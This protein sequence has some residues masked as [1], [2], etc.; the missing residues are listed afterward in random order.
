MT[1]KEILKTCI[2]VELARRNFFCFCNLMIPGMYDKK[3]HPYLKKLCDDL[4]DFWENDKRKYF[5]LS[6]PPRHGKTLTIGLF[7]DWV[8]GQDK[9]NKVMT[10]SYNEDYAG[11]LSKAIR[12]R[13]QEIKVDEDRVIYSDVF[14]SSIERGSAQAKKFKLNGSI[15]TNVLSTSINGSATGMGCNLLVLDDM[16]K[17]ASESYSSKQKQKIYD[18]F[19]NTM[20]SRLEGNKKKIILIGTRWCKDDLIGKIIEEDKEN[21]VVINIPV[22]DDEDKLLAPDIFSYEDYLEAKKK[23]SEEVFSANFIGIPLDVKDRMYRNI[24]EYEYLDKNYIIKNYNQEEHKFEVE[25][26]KDENGR[27]IAFVDTADTGSDYLSCIIAKILNNKIFIVDIYYTQDQM[28]ITEKV[29]AQKLTHFNVINCLIEGNNGG[30]GWARNVS[31]Y[32]N[33]MG[34]RFTRCETFTQRN[35]KDVRIFNNAHN[36]ENYVYFPFK[37]ENRFPEAFK[38][39]VEY[40]T[41]SKNEHDDFEDALTGVFEMFEKMGYMPSY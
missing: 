33:E 35:P 15:G 16:L 23:M 34:N 1:E 10:G 17:S 31:R 12:D 39:M 36:I 18:W 11:D 25:K 4:Q 3:K 30:R 29:V 5:C 24:N 32:L 14:E 22:I 38:S 19:S 21:C 13:I 27:V 8:L 41:K 28:E 2:R 26:I 20:F 9:D 37:W 7:V 40:K 6:I